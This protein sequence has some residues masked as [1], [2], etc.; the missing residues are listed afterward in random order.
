ML[1]L[2]AF[3]SCRAHVYLDVK[4]SNF[5]NDPLNMFQMTLPEKIYFMKTD[6]R[7]CLID[8]AAQGSMQNEEAIRFS[9]F[10]KHD[11]PLPQDFQIVKYDQICHLTIVLTVY[12]WAFVAT[13]L[14]LIVE[15]QSTIVPT[16]Q[17]ICSVL[18]QNL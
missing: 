6:V 3:E 7:E 2:I 18:K 9:L 14:Y 15:F 1:I 17:K 4:I 12:V 13:L 10:V 5:G 11:A 8:V 16:F